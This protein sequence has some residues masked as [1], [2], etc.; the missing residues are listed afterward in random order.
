M[1][2]PFDPNMLGNMGGLMG[3]LGGVQQKM[4][5]M[6]RKS[7]ETVVEG[8]ASGVVRVKMSCDFHV[9]AVIIDPKAMGDREMLEDLVRVAIDDATD[10]VRTELAAQMK[11]VMGGLPIPPGL[12]GF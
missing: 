5:E 1:S 4:E 6:K 7:A 9:K 10:K 2:N 11:G 3:M 12:L 8:T